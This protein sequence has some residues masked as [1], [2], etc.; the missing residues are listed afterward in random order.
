MTPVNYITYPCWKLY[1][2]VDRKCFP[3]LLKRVLSSDLKQ[4]PNIAGVLVKSC[5]TQFWFHLR[6]TRFHLT[7]VPHCFLTSQ[8]CVFEVSVVSASSY[9]SWHS[10]GEGCAKR[11]PLQSPESNHLKLPWG[12]GNIMWNQC[13]TAQNIVCWEAQKDSRCFEF[14]ICFSK[15]IIF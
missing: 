15:L 10:K 9:F 14:L 2:K 8:F 13:N 1:W 7:W 3:W 5:N 12:T 6:K 4:S 11:G